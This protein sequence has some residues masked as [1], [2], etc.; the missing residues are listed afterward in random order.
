M[1]AHGWSAPRVA[2]GGLFD[3]FVSVVEAPFKT[4]A[5]AVGDVL[6]VVPGG[7]W[8]Q[9]AFDSGKTWIGDMAR[10]PWGFTALTLI[11]G[12]LEIGIGGAAAGGG[13][14]PI[15]GAIGPQIASVAWGLPGV[16]KGDCFS[17]AYVAEF[18]HRLK[19]LADYF[20]GSAGLGD[21]VA[22]EVTQLVNDSAFFDFLTEAKQQAAALGV[23][24]DTKA[25][26][27]KAGAD[28]N[29]LA[30]KFN[31]RADSA[32]NASNLVLCEQIYD[33]SSFDPASGAA[34]ASFDPTSASAPGAAGQ[35]DTT[36]S[37]IRPLPTL[38]GTPTATD[39]LTAILLAQKAGVTDDRLI[40][41]KAQY[42]DLF[43]REATMTGTN[44][45]GPPPGVLVGSPSFATVAFLAGVTSLALVTSPAW[46]AW[47]YTRYRTSRR[48]TP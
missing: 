15:V 42:N 45:N 20:G 29:S 1:N 18:G 2:F 24:V 6:R 44:P 19:Q 33:T 12:Q 40:A 28:P 4:A 5:G 3:D 17:S 8:I 47:L 23:N 13:A 25:I 9:G 48:R 30:K 34:P 41:L 39:V 35:T 43:A 11:A 37:Q 14:S 22:A 31:V 38:K 16:L 27:R 7:T 46:G 10:T 26:L 21:S 32:A 36:A